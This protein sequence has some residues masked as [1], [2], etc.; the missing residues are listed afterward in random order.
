MTVESL[1]VCYIV[2]S[3]VSNMASYMTRDMKP[4]KFHD[5]EFNLS[6]HLQ[7]LAT[8]WLIALLISAYC[9]H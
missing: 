1:I 5:R 4:V 2:L 9:I 8:S 3:I 7:I 6:E